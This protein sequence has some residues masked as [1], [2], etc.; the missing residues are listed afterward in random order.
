MRAISNFDDMQTQEPVCGTM[1]FFEAN[2][3]YKHNNWNTIWASVPLQPYYSRYSSAPA[4]RW[5][6]IDSFINLAAWIWLKTPVQWW[7]FLQ[8]DMFSER[9]C[10]FLVSQVTRWYAFHSAHLQGEQRICCSSQK[11]FSVASTWLLGIP[12]GKDNGL[13]IQWRLVSQFL[14]VI[15]KSKMF[16]QSANYIM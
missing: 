9:W 10:R 16:K 4:L 13:V 12:E 11:A 1:R 5:A 15:F 14:L 2:T 3:V 7:G 8:A 6:A